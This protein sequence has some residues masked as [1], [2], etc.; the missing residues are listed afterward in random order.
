[1]TI[2]IHR[3]PLL[4]LFLASSAQ[5]DAQNPN[6]AVMEVEVINLTG[7]AIP[8]LFVHTPDEDFAPLVVHSGRR[9]DAN[10]TRH[11]GTLTF[12]RERK[13]PEGGTQMET[14]I[15]LS[16]QGIKRKGLLIFYRDSQ[17]R[18]NQRL[19]PDSSDHHT[20]GA[21][22]LLNLM[23]QDVLCLVGDH[24]VRLAGGE[25]SVR[26]DLKDERNR[27]RF[28]FAMLE[29]KPYR[30]PLSTLRLRFPEQRFTAIF[31]YQWKENMIAG[32]G[33]ERRFVPDVLRFYDLA[34]Q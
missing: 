3:I 9:G 22:R 12:F 8:P 7:S 6:A 19:L 10:L 18:I 11:N 15:E 34:P 1:M 31:T 29:P 30:S 32:G 16:A 5:V 33:S 23:E 26:S 28:A 25:D 2:P 13:L 20:S 24:R 4:V 14:A 17:D 21:A 27:F